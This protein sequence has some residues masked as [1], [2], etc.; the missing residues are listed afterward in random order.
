[1][2][3]QNEKQEKELKL[4]PRQHRLKDWLNDNFESGKFFSI[5][6]VVKGFVNEE[7]KPY[8]K[9]NTN[10]YKHDKCIALSNDVR[11]INWLVGIKR[12][13]PI[14][15]D[16]KGGVKLC[17]S[18]AE[19]DEFYNLREKRVQRH[20]QYL[21]TLKSMVEMDGYVPI[22]N[23]ANRVLSADEQKPIDTFKR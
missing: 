23:L 4:T 22:I 18:K 16:K 10:P 21:N 12:Y 8:Y 14:I 17:E 5:E 20:Y 15:K 13:I 3:M 1:M 11:A 6:E 7:G 19:F 9:L 2:I